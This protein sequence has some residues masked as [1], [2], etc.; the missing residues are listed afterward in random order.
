MSK[1]SRR[2]LAGG[3]IAVVLIVSLLVG[4]V[5]LSGGS[6]AVA[7]V[8]TRV[9]NVSTTTPYKSEIVTVT[10]SGLASTTNYDVAYLVSLEGLFDPFEFA[11]PA[12]LTGVGG[13]FAPLE[14][15]ATSDANGALTVQIPWVLDSEAMI[16][17]GVI[18]V[19][20]SSAALATIESFDDF[21]AVSP[22]MFPGKGKNGAPVFTF[23]GPGF[24]DGEFVAG[25]ELEV[26]ASG[27]PVGTGVVFGIAW[28]PTSPSTGDVSTDFWRDYLNCS[29]GEPAGYNCPDQSA[30][31]LVPDAEVEGLFVS[32]GIGT[33]PSEDM[34]VWVFHFGE[35]EGGGFFGYDVLTVDDFLALSEDEDTRTPTG[36]HGPSWIPFAGGQPS[37]PA[38]AGQLVLKD[39]SER[40]MTLSSPAPGQLRYSADGIRVTFTGGAGSSVANGLVVGPTGTVTCEVCATLAAGGVIETW[41]FSTPRLVAA[42][43]VADLPC[44]TFEIPFGAPL[45]GGAP[46]PSGVHTLQ[47]ALPS[48]SD[49]QAVNVGVTVGGPVPASVP[50]GDAPSIPVGLGVLLALLVAVAVL[51]RRTVRAHG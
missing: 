17:S 5:G 24:T 44:Q 51:P 19:Y 13:L 45:D 18:V 21:A 36:G 33:A 32:L 35:D 46:I 50:A 4:F 25:E 30:F 37:Q 22:Q 31:G 28:V 12:D 34:A 42:A 7:G 2:S 15:D 10:V 27:F 16:F 23:A 38:G 29:F 43:R 11:D 40:P 8:A 14:S 6:Q 39:G 48:G 41:L 3:R 49:A 20:A 1:T 9:A 47:L 26:T